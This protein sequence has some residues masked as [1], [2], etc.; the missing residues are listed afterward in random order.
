LFENGLIDETTYEL[1]ATDAEG[2][3]GE[4]CRL[5]RPDIND[6]PVEITP[7]AQA[8][9]GDSP[10]P[11]GV[12]CEVEPVPRMA[13]PGGSQG[14][15]PVT[16]IRFMIQF[17]RGTD[18]HERDRIEVMTRFPSEMYTVVASR[19]PHSLELLMSVD[20]EFAA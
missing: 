6:D 3:L 2:L 12:P 18:V 13:S 7:P 11:G 15:S 5:Y 8:W 19:S 14:G 1:T 17:K 10:D 4:R 16:P 9:T 20:V